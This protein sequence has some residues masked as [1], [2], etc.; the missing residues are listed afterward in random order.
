[1]AQRCPFVRR[2]VL[3]VVQRREA[4]TSFFMKQLSEASSG[5]SCKHFGT[6]PKSLQVREY[7]AHDIDNTGNA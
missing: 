4:G 1:M 3:S 5:R 2:G 7:P 6:F